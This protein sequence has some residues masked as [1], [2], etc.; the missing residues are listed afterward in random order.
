MSTEPSQSPVE[1]RLLHGHITKQILGAFYQVHHELG[2]GF[3]ESVYSA[4]LAMVLTELGLRVEREV[5]IA[6]YFRGARVGSFTADKIVE[7]AVVVEQKAV[8]S[9]PPIWEAQLLNYLRS[10]K[11]EVGLLLNFGPRATFKRLVWTN[12]RKL[13]GSS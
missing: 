9:L 11:L 13:L 1:D 3:V 12:D 6:V 8:H 7:S 10:T 4:A 5:P 2:F